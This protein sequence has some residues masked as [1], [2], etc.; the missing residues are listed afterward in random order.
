MV[1]HEKSSMEKLWAFFA[2][3]GL[4]LSRVGLNV[5][6]DHFINAAITAQWC[7][8]WSRPTTRV[9]IISV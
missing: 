5:A 9:I 2:D 6:A 8:V 7:L 3:K 4:V 1:R